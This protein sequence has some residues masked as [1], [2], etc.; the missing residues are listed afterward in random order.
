[1]PEKCSFF[2]FYHC[3]PFVVKDNQATTT[4]EVKLGTFLSQAVK[5]QMFKDDAK[6]RDG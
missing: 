3:T 5:Y 1:M 6:N 2:N 4:E